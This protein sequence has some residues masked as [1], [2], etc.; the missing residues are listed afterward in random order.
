MIIRP[1]QP[2]DPVSRLT[3]LLHSAYKRLLDLGMKYVATVQ[4]DAVTLDR[5]HQGQG[6]VAEDGGVLVGTIVLEDQKQTSGCTWYDRP[7]VASFHQFAVDPARQG[8]GIGLAL[9][10]HVEGVALAA[11]AK[12][13]ALDTSEWAA[14][15][16]D[17]YGS[18]GY[19]IVD[20]ARWQGVNY[21]SVIMSKALGDASRDFSR[22]P[23]GRMPEFV[24]HEPTAEH[25]EE[26]A[27]LERKIERGGFVTRRHEIF[28]RLGDLYR[29]LREPEKALK[30]L[31]MAAV[32]AVARG[33]QKAV[34]TQR[35]RSAIAYHYAG[36]HATANHL[37]A[38]LLVA[39]DGDSERLGFVHQHFG[40]CLAEQ[41]RL[42]EA[43]R[44]FRKAE[45][46]RA[47]EGVADSLRASTAEAIAE[48][49]NLRNRVA[50]E[51]MA[52][53][54]AGDTADEDDPAWRLACR[55][56][57]MQRLR[58]KR[59]LD[60]GCGPG[61]D[62][63]HLTDQGLDVTA[64]DFC[65]PFLAIVR[66][67]YPRMRTAWLD[68]TRPFDLGRFDGVYGHSCFLHISRDL[69]PATL[70]HLR[71]ALNPG[72]VLFLA[73]VESSK[74]RQYT[75]PDWG[76][77]A[78]NVTEFHCYSAEE[79]RALFEAA[80]FTDVEILRLAWSVDSSYR[81]GVAKTRM[82]EKGLS[83]FQVVGRLPG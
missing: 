6:F 61:T 50:Y 65:E 16:L 22:V 10:R 35:L 34:M 53:S 8:E 73:V 28:G 13:L 36:K 30:Y 39:F 60:I 58:G 68:V 77:I 62:A 23:L 18:L 59:V 7:E 15:L 32:A 9:I 17:W 41:D 26:A 29:I 71:N 2:S 81:R 21:R 11:G 5:L 24:R 80:G 48:L 38:R 56:A 67:R 40:K 63:K 44:H 1:F 12:E 83:P 27:E 51:R 72:G 66:Q 75:L 20:E 19:R 57:F 4:E 42:D 43:M 45:E 54:Y 70:L 55:G 47:E 79:M 37:F 25:R 78:G 46:Y 31:E 76:G 33:D 64:S 52:S 82:E 49:G 69:A 74:F 14:H 3:D